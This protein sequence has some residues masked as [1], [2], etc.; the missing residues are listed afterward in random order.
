MRMLL[1]IFFVGLP[2]A[3]HGQAESL[4]SLRERCIPESSENTLR[5]IVEV[6]SGGNP[7]AMQ[8][9]FP[10]ALLHRWK[11]SPGSLRLKRQ[12]TDQK[13]ALEWLNALA[14][15]HIFVDL[16]LMQISTAEANRLGIAPASLLDPCTNLRV[17]WRILQ[18]DYTAEARRSGP[19]QD[20][21]KHAISRY[22]TGD[23]ERGVDN[24]YVSRVLAAVRNVANVQGGHK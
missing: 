11:L 19:G 17:G 5:A 16:G 10:R 2:I 20:A 22:N 12:P 8:I 3:L 18:E 1:A 9:D 21:L 24:G 13:E 6:E 15:F 23:P 7:S 4:A 14:T